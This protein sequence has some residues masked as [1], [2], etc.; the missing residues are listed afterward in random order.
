[1]SITNRQKADNCHEASA[2]KLLKLLTI[3]TDVLSVEIELHPKIGDCKEKGQSMLN[4]Q[5]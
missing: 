1:M 3:N 4:I 2:N 5:R